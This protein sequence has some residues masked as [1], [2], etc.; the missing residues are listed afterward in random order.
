MRKI[1]AGV[2]ALVM[3]LVTVIP[4]QAGVISSFQYLGQ[5]TFEFGPVVPDLNDFPAGGANNVSGN[6]EVD[7]GEDQAFASRVGFGQTTPQLAYGAGAVAAGSVEVRSRTQVTLEITNDSALERTADWQFLIFAGG[8]G[9]NTPDFTAANCDIN[10]ID[11]CGTWRNDLTDEDV[12]QGDLA[13]VNFSAELEDATPGTQTL[14]S[15]EIAVAGKDDDATTFTQN[16]DG[17]AL[18]GLAESNL[19]YSWGETLLEKSLG[20]FGAGETK[21]LTFITDTIASA[22]G[23]CFETSYCVT[24]FAGFGDPPGG[25]GRVMYRLAPSDPFSGLL[26]ADVF[27]GQVVFTDPTG[28]TEPEVDIPEA[29]TPPGVVPIPGTALLLLAGLWPALSFGRRRRG[30]L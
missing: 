9:L 29:Q 7:A 17:V 4:A 11:Q 18:N 25:G 30:L 13:S 15:G 20:I 12:G 10:S 23:A 2:L 3:G 16:F 26:P 8:A 27:N 24:G 21:T 1:T 22:T 14:F 19:E 5:V 6:F 28:A